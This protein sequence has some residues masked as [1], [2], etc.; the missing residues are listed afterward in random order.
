[1]NVELFGGGIAVGNRLVS[2]RMWNSAGNEVAESDRIFY[3]WVPPRVNNAKFD[4][5]R[6][7]LIYCPAEVLL[8]SVLD[9]VG[10]VNQGNTDEASLNQTKLGELVEEINCKILT[11]TVKT[12]RSNEN[13]TNLEIDVLFDENNT[14]VEIASI[15]SQDSPDPD[16]FESWEYLAERLNNFFSN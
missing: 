7:H 2:L 16:T 14:V 9:L 10:Q 11:A 5:L 13:E 12:I 6:T 1:M 4:E 15:S 8:D 3:G